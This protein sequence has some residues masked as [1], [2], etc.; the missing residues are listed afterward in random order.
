MYPVTEAALISALARI[1]F[2]LLSC[3]IGF[4]RDEIYNYLIRTSDHQNYDNQGDLSKS[5]ETLGY[6][7]KKRL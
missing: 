6:L 1:Y 4:V 3:V 7:Q 5:S 2:E